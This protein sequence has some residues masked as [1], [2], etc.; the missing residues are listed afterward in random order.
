MQSVRVL[1]KL[2]LPMTALAPQLIDHGLLRD[3]LRGKSQP[4]VWRGQHYPSVQ[5][6]AA[7]HGVNPDRIRARLKAGITDERLI[8]RRS[9]ARK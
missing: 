4:M 6:F 8:S 1:K 3:S 2:R 7:K 5:A 9:L